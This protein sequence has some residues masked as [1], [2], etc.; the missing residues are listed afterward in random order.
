MDINSPHIKGW[1]EVAKRR[2]AT[3]IINVCD[4]FDC[5]DYPVYVMPKDNLNE[6]L[7][8][9]RDADMQTINGIIDVKLGCKII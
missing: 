4:T 1:I 3:H 6:K 5:E 7:G 2:G 8:E 9:S